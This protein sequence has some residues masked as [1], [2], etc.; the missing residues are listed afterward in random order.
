[1][2]ILVPARSKAKACVCG[3]SYAGIASSNP[4]GG[5]NVVSVVCSQS[6]VRWADQSSRGALPSAVGSVC[7]LEKHRRGTP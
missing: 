5:M 3:R 7:V 1:M 2:P 4:A 6:S